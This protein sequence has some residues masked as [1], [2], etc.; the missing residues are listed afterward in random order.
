MAEA[1]SIYPGLRLVLVGPQPSPAG[2]MALQ[3][4]QLQR[5]LQQEGAHVQ[6]VPTNAPHRPQWLAR[7]RGLRAVARLVFYL[8][9]LWR[10]AQR[11]DL[12]H[13]MSNSGWSWHLFTVPAVWVAWLRGVPVVVNYRGGAAA[14]FLSRSARWVRLSMAR[15]ASLVVPSG[16]LVEVFASHRMPA[17]VVANIVDLSC[18]K[19]APAL[20]PAPRVLVARNLEPVYDIATAIRAFARVQA[21]R[22]D[23]RLV[24]A[25]SGPEE[26]ALRQLAQELGLGDSV[27]FSGRLSREEMADE[28][29]RSR[30]ALNP[31][32]V[33]NM[34]NAVIE[35]LAC[36]VPVVSTRVGGV[37]YMVE[38]G[39]TALLVPAGEPEAMAQALLRL[40]NDPLLAERLRSAGLQ[41]AARWSWATAGPAWA[42]VYHRALAGAARRH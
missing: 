18:F 12:M 22:P 16:F 28:L 3:T 34:P 13:V 24:L 37:P 23:A 40:L 42:A 38:D 2:G 41:S 11:A 36:G 8:A 4:L 1:T 33:D 9:A 20:C 39:S 19:P 14:P 21:Q 6:L 32:R 29:R 5:L 35:A 15:A 25:G 17:E 31:S 27:H 7:W 26:A 30:V 10:G